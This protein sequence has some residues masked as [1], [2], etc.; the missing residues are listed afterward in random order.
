[1]EL[2]THTDNIA[3]IAK[4]V[5][6][7]IN[8][9]G[10]DLILGVDANKNIIGIDDAENEKKKIHKHLFAYIKPIPPVSLHVIHYNE[11]DII[12]INVW[13]GAQKPY[14]LKIA[15][16]TTE[17]TIKKAIEG[18]IKGTTEGTKYKLNQIVLTIHQKPGIRVPEIEKVTGIPDKTLERH[19]KKLKEANL[20]EF[21]GDA[22]QT[23]GYYLIIKD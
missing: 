13:M 12:L 8:T 17:G 7:L 15:E 16:G 10:G 22:R 11:K 2:I 6:A 4:V 23:G 9:Q 21:R 5:T 14:Q 3:N 19:I 1:L 18:A 20:I